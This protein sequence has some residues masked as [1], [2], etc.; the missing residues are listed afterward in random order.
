MPRTKSLLRSLLAIGAAGALAGFGTFSAFSSSTENP[1]N[2]IDAG[3]VVLSDND[4]GSALYDVSGAKAG[5]TVD[6]CITVSYSGDLDADV[7]LYLPDPVGAL[8]EYVN[9]TVTPGTDPSPAFGDCTGFVAD[10]API[11]NGTL[12]GFRAGHSSWANGLADNP[13]ST[14]EWAQGDEVTYRVQLTVQDDNDAQGKVTG[15]HRLMWE[16]R[17]Q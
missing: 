17:N 7:K 8:A 16:A 15:T 11:F 9:M 1:G 3:T 13:G 4:N 14:S 12:D 10:G 2:K 5:T 6:R